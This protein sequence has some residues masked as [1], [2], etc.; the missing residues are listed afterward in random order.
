MSLPDI[1]TQ[2]F[3]TPE[4]TIDPITLGGFTLPQLSIPAITT[5]AF[6]I[7]PIA[8]GGFTL[9]QIMTPE[10]TTPPFA[11]DPI[12]LSGFTL[13][14]SISRRSPRQSSPSSRWAWRPS[15]HPHSP[16]PASTCR[17]PP[18]TD[19]QSQ[20][21]RDTSTRAQRPR[22][23]FQRRNR[24][25]LGLRQQRLGTVGLVQHKSCW[26]AS[27][28]GLPELRWS[29]LRLLQPWQRHIGL[30]QHR[31]PAVCR[32]QL[33]L[34]FGQHRQQPVGPV[35]PEHHA[36]I[37]ADPAPRRGSPAVIATIRSTT[38]ATTSTT[39]KSSGN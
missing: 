15:P 13:P 16:S 18:W 26:A 37:R 8:L 9:P 34:R 31:H 33:G 3:T 39:M 25:E 22:R 24:W 21:G 23:A 32:D 20:R 30:R 4:L 5:P 19:S 12:E 27:R 36:I 35:L 17:A 11:I 2:Q 7:D 14:R 6:T 1:T 28:L 10:I 38:P 29:Y